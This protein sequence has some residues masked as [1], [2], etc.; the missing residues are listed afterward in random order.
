MQMCHAS[1]RHVSVHLK[2]QVMDFPSLENAHHE[3]RICRGRNS[4]DV[5]GMQASSTQLCNARPRET[6]PA[7]WVRHRIGVTIRA[8]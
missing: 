8:S 5:G 6:C 7:T 4:Y 3:I 2:S 1:G